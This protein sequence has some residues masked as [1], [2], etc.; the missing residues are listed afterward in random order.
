MSREREDRRVVRSR[1]QLQDAL[2]ALVLEKD[3]D[4]ISVQEILD[5]AG[6]G[7]ATFYAHFRD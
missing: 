2:R 5:R 4:K 6:V 7:R 3:Y 1:A